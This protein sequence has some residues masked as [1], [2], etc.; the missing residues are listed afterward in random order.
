MKKTLRLG[1]SLL[2][3]LLCSSFGL[4]EHQNLKL[5]PKYSSAVDSLKRNT[6]AGVN[7]NKIKPS[8]PST[9]P[10]KAPQEKSR[11]SSSLLRSVL[12]YF[13]LGIKFLASLLLRM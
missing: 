6:Q 7:I 5:K 8:Q 3:L 1:F 9:M 13:I 10:E 12:G 11:E 2:A 4:V